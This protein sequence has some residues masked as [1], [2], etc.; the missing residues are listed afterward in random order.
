[1][2]GCVNKVYLYHNISVFKMRRDLLHWD[3]ALQLAKALAPEQIPYISREYAQQLEFTG[4]YLN[5]LSHFEKGITQ[6]EAQREH[7]EVCAAGIAR[8]SIR[9]GDI[10]RYAAYGYIYIS[11]Y[12][13]SVC[14]TRSHNG[15]CCHVCL[16]Y[17]EVC[18]LLLCL[19]FWRFLTSEG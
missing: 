15:C 4:D 14:I 11:W 17:P 2:Y 1:M 6:I 10:R 13:C 9:V 16:Y 5:A 7:D 12:I 8:M 18:S 3:S 19:C